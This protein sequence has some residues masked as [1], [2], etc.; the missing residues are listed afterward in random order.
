MPQERL[1]HLENII[2]GKQQDFYEVGKALNEIKQGRLYRLTL[3]DSFGAYVC[4]PRKAI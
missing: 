1:I 4:Q 3:H 2:A